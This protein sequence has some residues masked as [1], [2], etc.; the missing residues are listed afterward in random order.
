M[1]MSPL[2]N[3]GHRC[4][5]LVLASLALVLL[6]ASPVWACSVCFAEDSALARYAYYGTTIGMILLPAGMVAAFAY[7]I[8]SAESEPEARS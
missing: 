2:R 3:T 6:L 1:K 7:W 8:R 4:F 5:T